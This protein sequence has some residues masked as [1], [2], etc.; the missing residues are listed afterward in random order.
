[1][2][3]VLQQQTISRPASFSGVGLHSGNRVNMTFLPAPPGSGIRFRRVDLEGKPFIDPKTGRMIE[4]EEFQRLTAVTHPMEAGFGDRAHPK[5][6]AH[7]SAGFF[8]VWHATPDTLWYYWNRHGRL[9]G[10][11]IKTRRFIGLAFIRS[12]SFQDVL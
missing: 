2:L 8:K 11:D 5:G 7:G 10:Y 6:W 4:A 3:A 1:M 12:D 9:A